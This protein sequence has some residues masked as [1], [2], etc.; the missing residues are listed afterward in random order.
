MHGTFVKEQLLNP[1]P[2]DKRCIIFDC[3]C[4]F[5]YA[6]QE[7][8]VFSLSVAGT[9]LAD[10]KNN[11]RY[12]NKNYV[13][14]TKKE[15]RRLSKLGYPYYI[16]AS[17]EKAVIPVVISVGTV[18]SFGVKLGFLFQLSLSNDR[19]VCGVDFRYIFDKDSLSITSHYRNEDDIGWNRFAWVY[20]EAP[21]ER[22]KSITL[23]EPVLKED[24]INW[25][26]EI[27]TPFAS[28]LD[29]ILI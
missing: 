13:T 3:G 7:D 5:P 1:F 22:F 25:F 21:D 26:S 6:N 18:D 28:T 11:N 9:V 2:T 4:Y 12:P 20:G 19:P 29:D 24:G 17:K 10:C 16:D 15:G 23:K 14:I 27:I 8:L